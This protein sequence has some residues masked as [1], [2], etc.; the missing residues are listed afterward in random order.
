MPVSSALSPSAAASEREPID[1]RRVIRDMSQDRRRLIRMRIAAANRRDQRAVDELNDQI[2][3]LSDEGQALER[4]TQT[5]FQP[6]RGAELDASRDRLNVAARGAFARSAS[7]LTDRA[8]REIDGLMRDREDRFQTLDEGSTPVTA[9]DVARA[10][11]VRRLVGEA[12]RD[13]ANAGRDLEFAPVDEG[14]TGAIGVTDRRLIDRVMAREGLAR[15][16]EELALAEEAALVEEAGTAAGIERQTR[17]Q[18]RRNQLAEL[19]RQEAAAQRSARLDESAD[20]L[21]G[22]RQ[23][24]ETIQNEAATEE[25]RR[26]ISRQNRLRDVDGVPAGGTQ[27]FRSVEERAKNIETGENITYSI[28]KKIEAGIEGRATPQVINQMEPDIQSIERNVIPALVAMIDSG[29]P[30]QVAVAIEQAGLMLENL[31]SDVTGVERSL[32][33]SV[34]RETLLAPARFGLGIASVL[35][36][37]GKLKPDKEMDKASGLVRRIEKIKS[38]LLAITQSASRGSPPDV[39]RLQ[40]VLNTEFP[41]G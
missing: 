3:T 25:I 1:S 11:R 12:N 4:S 16:R 35:G 24:F 27:A 7:D 37:D 10:G 21:Q 18:M 41:G 6:L 29:D 13:Q 28:G 40:R 22:T 20:A 38:D 15:R 19:E 14:A 31:P 33:D 30:Q 39:D 36:E 17:E 34:L 5:R 32:V 26:E 2:R 9:R 8:G 23:E